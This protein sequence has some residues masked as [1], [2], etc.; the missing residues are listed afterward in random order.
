MNHFKTSIL[1]S[2]QASVL[3]KQEARPLILE[4]KIEEK[5]WKIKDEEAKLVR[6]IL[7]GNPIFRRGNNNTPKPFPSARKRELNQGG[8]T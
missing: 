8:R 3:A 2:A 4:N 1:S 7:S 5:S 6:G